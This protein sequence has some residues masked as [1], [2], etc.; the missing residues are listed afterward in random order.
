VD[1][2]VQWHTDPRDGAPDAKIYNVTEAGMERLRRWVRSAYV[3]P[4][5]FQDP[6]FTFRLRVGMMLREPGVP[7]LV[8]QELAARQEQVRLNR[9]RPYDTET[10]D[11]RPEIDAEALDFISHELRHQG[12]RQIDDWIAWLE[13]L[14]VTLEK[15]AAS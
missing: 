10:D 12:E 15:R 1:G 9:N 4:R 6:E 8:R 14:L 3:P 2:W 11:D 5:R 13:K 7:D